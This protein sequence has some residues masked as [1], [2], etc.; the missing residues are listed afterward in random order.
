M[1]FLVRPLVRSVVRPLGLRAVVMLSLT[2]IIQGCIP[3][4]KPI[5]EDLE[6]I[7]P[8]EDL[9]FTDVT[10]EQANSEG[11]VLWKLESVRATY[12]D[13][14]QIALVE[15]PFGILFRD[16]EA[17]YE[18]E[19][20]N[21]EVYQDGEKILL[22]D[23]VKITHLATQAVLKGDRL[24]W[25]PQQEL[26]VIQGNLVGTYEDLEFTANQGHY[27]GLDEIITLEGEI[28]AILQDSDLRLTTD[29]LEWQVAAETVTGPNPTLIER[30]DPED[31]ETVVEWAKGDSLQVDLATERSTLSPNAQVSL[32][33]PP[34]DIT[35]DTLTW[36]ALQDLVETDKPLDI[37][38]RD[39]KIAVSADRGSMTLETE[40]VNLEGNVNGFNPQEQ[41]RLLANQVT[42]KIQDQWVEAKG[43]VTYTAT[44]PNLVI[45]GDVAVGQLDKGTI[46]V[47][48][49]Q[50][51]K[52][53][54]TLD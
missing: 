12:Q 48:D 14:Q 25:Y 30:F 8:L 22:W 36:D 16:D 9:V 23:Q 26:L 10:L 19:A 39:N 2:A 28:V 32:N 20:I 54:Y 52:T 34:L 50:A 47:E 45:T 46:K 29:Y 53:V 5:E 35:S 11:Q 33:S 42:W 44:N 18:V 21:G 27:H 24:E 1:G 37:L 43:E 6:G 40:V 7:D 17:T 4:F 49:S 41:A 3:G 38:H 51:V 13:D 31:P 15:T